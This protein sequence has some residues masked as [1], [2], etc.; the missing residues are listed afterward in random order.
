MKKL[1]KLNPHSPKVIDAVVARI[2]RMTPEEVWAFLTY[3][4]PGVPET[5]MTGMFSDHAEPK[6]EESD[7]SRIASA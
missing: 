2:R 6:D 5:D 1:K 7:K 3:R 4:E